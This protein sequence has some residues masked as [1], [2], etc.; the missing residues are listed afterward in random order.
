MS[1]SLTTSRTLSDRVAEE[2][3]VMMAR[4]LLKQSELAKLLDTNDQW[5]SV[6]LRGR[7]PIDLNDLERI[8]DALGADVADLIPSGPP[9]PSRRRK[10]RTTAYA[11]A[12]VIDRD[13]PQTSASRPST[14]GAKTRPTET[15]QGAFTRR[16]G[17]AV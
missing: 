8:A 10:G 13:R 2:I 3:R 7:Q 4:R 9:A 15:R 12:R 6:R 17:A 11:L 1:T 14:Y 5:L 16:R